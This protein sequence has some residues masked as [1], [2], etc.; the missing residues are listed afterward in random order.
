MDIDD[1]RHCRAGRRSLLA[2]G[3]KRDLIYF[4]WNLIHKKKDERQLILLFI[5]YLTYCTA[6]IF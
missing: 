5:N 1:S 2:V 3:E 4:F 6:R